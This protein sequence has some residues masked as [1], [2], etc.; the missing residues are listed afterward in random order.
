MN[1]YR[2]NS[3]SLS[4]SDVDDV[5][6]GIYARRASF[7]D[8]TPDLQIGGT[9]AAPSGTY[10]DGDPPT[11]GKEYAYELENDPETEGFNVWTIDFTA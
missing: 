1:D 3:C 7:T 10:Q 8:A 5:L 9:N 4:Q 2:Y 6:A 11:T